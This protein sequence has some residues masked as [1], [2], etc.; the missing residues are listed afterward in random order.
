MTDSPWDKD[1]NLRLPEWIE[2][3]GPMPPTWP[4]MLFWAEVGRQALEGQ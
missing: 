4:V 3:A 1:G 2:Q